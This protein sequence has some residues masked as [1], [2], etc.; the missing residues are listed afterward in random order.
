MKAFSKITV[1]ALA[2]ISSAS[3]LCSCEM[4]YYKEELYRKEIFIVSEENNIIGQEFDYGGDE[5]LLAIYA[6]GTIGVEEDVTVTL[7]IDPNAIGEYNQRNFDT[8]FDSYAMELPAANYSINPMQVK[9]E[10][11]SCEARC[12]IM[13]NVDD[14]LPD[15][16]YFIPLRI[17]SVSF[18]M[19]SST[20]NFVLFE[21]FRKNNYATTK[22]ATY[23]T[24]NGTAQEGWVID[25][26]FGS[27]TRRQAI[28]SSKLVLPIDANSIR[29]LPAA[30]VLSAKTEIRNSSIRV[31][32]DP[33]SWVNVP[34]YSE[35]E[36]TDKV[37]PMQKVTLSPYIDSND[38]ITVIA[39][40]KDVCAYDPETKTF[41]L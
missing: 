30:K 12:P 31:T 6:S 13:V 3:F 8:Q 17:E 29:I 40:P 15:E 19:A 22:S 20:K 25:N 10:A 24:M 23:Y 1:F 11:G 35:G 4:E 38:A 26:I 2:A 32:I 9:L 41:Y 33:N 28:N 36:L 39:S 14:L 34:I 18:Y 5:G 16:T 7:G 37:K 27:N 21:V